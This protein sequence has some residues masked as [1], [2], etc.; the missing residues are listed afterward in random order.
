[1]RRRAPRRLAEALAALSPSLAPGTSLARVQ[2]IWEGVAGPAI[3]AHCTPVGE[4]G[5]VLALSCDEAVWSA[6]VELMGPEIVD[7]V[8][9]ALG[10]PEIVSMRVRTAAANEA[11][12]SAY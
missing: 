3:A 5:G 10:R 9:A 7:C 1:M 2:A 12:N 8:T 11:R 4:R 6:E